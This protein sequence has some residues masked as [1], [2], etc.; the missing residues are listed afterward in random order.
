M[1]SVQANQ[2]RHFPHRLDFWL[3]ET[4]FQLKIIYKQKVSSLISLCKLH[5]IIWDNTLRTCIKPCI[6]I[7]QAFLVHLC[8]I[9]VNAFLFQIKY[10]KVIMMPPRAVYPP[11]IHFFRY[12]DYTR[13]KQNRALLI[14]SDFILLSH[15][16]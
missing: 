14:I 11:D 10:V 8:T 3:K 13:P 12:I 2:G 7:L 9:C 1:Q 15:F 4:S 16:I 5:R 6:R